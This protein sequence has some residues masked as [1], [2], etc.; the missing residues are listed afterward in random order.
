MQLREEIVSKSDEVLR[1]KGEN[2]RL[3]RE[4]KL[5]RELCYE[6]P[7][8]WRVTTKGREG[9]FC[10]L[11]YDKDEKLIRLQS[12]TFKRGLWHCACCDKAFR[13]GGYVDEDV[14]SV[15]WGRRRGALHE[16]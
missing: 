13:D 16:D 15:T 3:Q 11:C 7:Y 14:Q 4:L 6:P 8:Y 2:A 10:Q 5:S 1:L 12:S 9:P